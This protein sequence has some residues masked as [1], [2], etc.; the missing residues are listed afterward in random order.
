M[1]GGE[2][3]AVLFLDLDGFKAINDT[4]GHGAGDELLVRVTH[5]LKGALNGADLLARLGGDEFTVLAR[6]AT[7]PQE[8]QALAWHLVRAL[9]V[10]L[11][12]AG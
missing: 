3:F 9:D 12:A 1:Q 11:R 8:A 5:V 6:T 2:P 10:P 4:L 7:T